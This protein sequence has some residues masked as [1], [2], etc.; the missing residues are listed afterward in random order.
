MGLDATKL[1]LLNA[2]LQL[3][4]PARAGKRD[5]QV[6]GHTRVNATSSVGRAIARCVLKTHCLYAVAAAQPKKSVIGGECEG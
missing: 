2:L 4:T 3:A 5:E 1:D 6:L